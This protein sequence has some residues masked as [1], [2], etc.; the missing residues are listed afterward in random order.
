VQ[1]LDRFEETMEPDILTP[2]PKEGRADRFEETP[3]P[4][5]TVAASEFRSLHLNAWQ[6]GDPNWVFFGGDG[7]RAGWSIALM[8]ALLYI[9][10]EVFGTVL[11][12]VFED[13]LQLKVAGGSALS[14]ILGETEWVAALLASG[15][16]VARLERRSILEYNLAGPRRV[17]HFLS[18]SAAGFVALSVLVWVMIEGGW[19]HPGPVAL[20]GAQIFKYGALW[21]AGF[22][23]VGLVE[24]GT[25][26]CYLQFTLMRGLNFWWALGSVGAL[27]LYLLVTSRGHGAWGVYA[28]A[29]MGVAPCLWVQLADRPGGS[30]WQAAWV[31]STGF[32]F[33]HTNNN[34]EN[35]IGIF[36]AAA[37]GF[38][39]CVSVRVTG[40]AWWAIGCH[41][42]W[43]W[44]ESYFYG[45]ADSGFAAKGHFLTTTLTGPALWSGGADGPEG[46][47]L[48][49][50]VVL[51]LLLAVL[52]LHGRGKPPQKI[53]PVVEGLAG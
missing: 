39:F 29:L 53:A 11:S 49:L 21:G 47:L 52:V 10:V 31:T 48:V 2:A 42:S 32:G 46:S 3:V 6:P 40:S 25:F 33:I 19:M 50:P 45:T 51:L 7:L 36:A 18:G 14:T 5:A 8:A 27:C 20:S 15:L 26:R 23:L 22:V 30:F 16:I 1:R 12:Y 44:A 43:D 41:A 13:L 37:I 28:V 9:F 38:V 24:E 35:W 17:V 4:T 34:G